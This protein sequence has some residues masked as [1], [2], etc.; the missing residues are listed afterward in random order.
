MKLI[1]HIALKDLRKH[2]LPAAFWVLLIAGKVAV[3]VWMLSP[4]SA[5]PEWFDRMRSANGVLIGI[6]T[7]VSCLLTAAVVLEDAVVGSNLFWVTRPIAGGLLL[8]AKLLGLGLLFYV[9][10]VLVWLSW[11][12][13][14]GFG[15]RDMSGA[16]AALWLMQTAVVVPAFVLATLVGRSG[17]FLQ[18]V[19]I[20][21]AG[22]V[23]IASVLSARAHAEPVVPETLAEIRIWLGVGLAGL[24]AVAVAWLQYTT[25]RTRRSVVFACAGCAAAWGSGT[26]WPW[27]F[28]QSRNPQR[29]DLAGTEPVRL[30]LRRAAYAEKSYRRLAPDQ[31]EVTLEFAA[32]HRARELLLDD[33]RAVVTLRWRDGTKFRQEVRLWTQPDAFL[34]KQVGL[35]G[36]ATVTD[37]ET[38][39]YREERLANRRPQPE[40]MSPYEPAQSLS[41]TLLI[42]ATL[43]QRF[44]EEK[45]SCSVSATLRFSRPVVR[46]EMPVAHGKSRSGDAFRARIVATKTVEIPGRTP[47]NEEEVVVVFTRL[48]GTSRTV[49]FVVQRSTGYVNFP[50]GMGEQPFY[51]HAWFSSARSVLHY[52]TPKVRRGEQWVPAPGSE[53]AFSLIAVTYD[54]AGEARRQFELAEFPWN[55]AN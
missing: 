32:T 5:D 47:G 28:A 19:L 8:A 44:A 40:K 24:T 52:R 45:P 54:R 50:S 9:V 17:R 41:G 34:P 55:A 12:L 7:V 10:P 15:V 20:L 46:L 26:A 14:C 13:A 36:L 33:G 25:R 3:N 31:K 6:E 38:K 22:F 4:A 27:D 21:L 53:Q 37:P 51:V 39:R 1:W 11:W 29:P 42:P 2:W 18:V 23:T 49:L 48:H 35:P 16:V 43:A 30:E